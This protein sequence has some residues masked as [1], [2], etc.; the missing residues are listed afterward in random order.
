MRVAVRPRVNEVASDALL[1]Q[2]AKREIFSLR[3]RL[4]EIETAALSRRTPSS[5]MTAITPR[6]GTGLPLDAHCKTSGVE[7]LSKR[8]LI[9]EVE[10]L[11]GSASTQVG[12]VGGS[13]HPTQILPSKEE[14]R[15]RRLDSSDRLS[16]NSAVAQSKYWGNFRR[17]SGRDDRGGTSEAETDARQRRRQRQSTIQ[18]SVQSKDRGGT[19]PDGYRGRDTVVLA[20]STPV[21][22]SRRASDGMIRI[23]VIGAAS[24]SKTRGVFS[25]PVASAGQALVPSHRGQKRGG[26]VTGSDDQG[27]IATVALMERF[28]C[29]EGELLRELETWKRR[30]EKLREI[31]PVRDTA[32]CAAGSSA[33]EAAASSRQK[34][35]VSPEDDERTAETNCIA[36][37]SA[38]SV[39]PPRPSLSS[40]EHGTVVVMSDI[41]GKKDSSSDAPITPD[42][43]AGPPPRSG[44]Q[45][46]ERYEGDHQV[47]SGGQENGLGVAG[48]DCAGPGRDAWVSVLF[49]LVGE[50]EDDLELKRGDRIKVW[51]KNSALTPRLTRRSKR[52]RG[53]GGV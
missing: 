17:D 8:L 50:R 53:G 30:C 44:A 37:I 27:H 11:P 52:W 41:P 45:R 21:H 1:L 48:M 46:T 3:R 6:S 20:A 43:G 40:G 2:R 26:V 10:E 49:D 16:S 15:Q 14:R 19:A 12:L 9:A 22:R 38:S 47:S 4:R 23:P 36:G 28:S 33:N 25:S 18:S 35:R 24:L 39:P 51:S 42:S 31:T 29:R 32:S 7:D 13:R 5:G 34:K